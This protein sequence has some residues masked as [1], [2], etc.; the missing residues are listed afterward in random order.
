[1]WSV[2]GIVRVEVLGAEG[3]VNVETFG[4]Q[5]PYVKACLFVGTDDELRYYADKQ[6]ASG[7]LSG[8]TAKT[9]D[10]MK[11]LI[12][13]VKVWKRTNTVSD[14]GRL[15]SIWP[16]KQDDWG[17]SNKM[18]FRYNGRDDRNKPLVRLVLRVIDEEKVMKDRDIGSTMIDLEKLVLRPMEITK[19]QVFL[20]NKGGN[21]SINVTFEPWSRLC[22]R[23][24][25]TIHFEKGTNLRRVA[26]L[27]KEDPYVAVTLLPW[28][29][30]GRSVS[31]FNG[32]RNDIVWPG[33]III[34]FPGLDNNSISKDAVNLCLTVFDQETVT[35]DRFMG[36][37]WAP[38]TSL[39]ESGK[40][41][42]IDIQ[43][44][45]ET[46]VDSAGILSVKMQ[47]E[48]Q[49]SL[50]DKVPNLSNTL[51]SSDGVKKALLI[52]INYTGTENS[53]RGCQNDVLNIQKMLRQKYNVE[54]IRLLTDTSNA[55][56]RDIPT[57]KNI[58]LGLQWLLE[59]AKS[60]DKLFLHFSGHGTHVPDDN[61]DEE[62]GA[63]ESL[64]PLDFGNDPE[65]WITDDELRASFFERVPLGC[66][67]TAIFDCCHSGT[68][69][70]LKLINIGGAS[71]SM[72]T[73]S[74]VASRFWPPCE[75]FAE[76][77]KSLS[78][79]KKKRLFDTNSIKKR[80]MSI[81]RAKEGSAIAVIS[82]CKDNQTS[83]DAMI[84]GQYTGALTWA[85][86]SV[87]NSNDKLS[88]EAFVT[89]VR[90]QLE[91]KYE[92]IPQLTVGNSKS[93]SS[94]WMEGWRNGCAPTKKNSKN[95]NEI[96]N[97]AIVHT[98]DDSTPNVANTEITRDIQDVSNE[99]NLVVV[100]NQNSSVASNA[101]LATN[102]TE[103]EEVQKSD[104]VPNVAKTE[105]LRDIQDV[106]NEINLVVEP[107]QTSSVARNPNL[108]T[109]A[110]EKEEIVSSDINL[111]P[112]EITLKQTHAKNDAFHKTTN[113]A[114]KVDLIENL[115]ANKSDTKPSEMEFSHQVTGDEELPDINAN[116]EYE[117]KNTSKSKDVW[118]SEIYGTKVS[119]SSN[120]KGISVLFQKS[121]RISPSTVKTKQLKKSI[122]I[123]ENPIRKSESKH[124][125]KRSTS[126][127]DT[128]GS[129]FTRLHSQLD[130]KD[131][132]MKHQVEKDAYDAIQN[133]KE[134]ASCGVQQTYEE[135][136]KKQ[137]CCPKCGAKY[138]HKITWQTVRNEFMN[139]NFKA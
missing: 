17:R 72:K 23:G 112:E 20:D 6:E 70:D 119:K 97:E 92:Q 98:R 114:T 90:K 64:V 45:D 118:N 124:Q 130:A 129:F 37:G 123:R 59:G 75:A 56:K 122:R 105:I 61:G 86:L 29:I 68:M 38:L 51:G 81:S 127:D 57:A 49:Y 125:K 131:R 113:E 18:S 2:P 19:H 82:G 26:S 116:S 44:W 66:D 1:M 9:D 7:F 107:N 13:N 95:S 71:T 135:V 109:N 32:G 3:L 117:T 94:H 133:K 47:F 65:T 58:R 55:D 50:F 85:V 76:K 115:E 54:N 62:D 128:R 35:S 79:G 74:D 108:S 89:Q 28:D 101:N 110:T 21:V 30:R 22:G 77:I 93:L 137:K 4:K 87:M 120:N 138:A 103:K 53:L 102:A 84:D 106:S 41:Q 8:L 139:R 134:C 24:N 10:L 69:S 40:E 48:P 16:E 126:D 33:M 83:A 104:S 99:T 132:T 5:D 111:K 34:P 42:T 27:S 14:G 78:T 39:I 80:A 73:N 25:I 31:C 36:R 60:G 67:V 46:G 88:L 12:Q 15:V 121:N 11:M 100:P 136:R 96:L 63:D 91:E 43:L 52:G